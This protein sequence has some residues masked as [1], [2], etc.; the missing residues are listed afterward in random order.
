MLD[1]ESAKSS[2]VKYM[3]IHQKDFRV[4]KAYISMFMQ[5]LD[6]GLWKVCKYSPIPL[7]SL[8]VNINCIVLVNRFQ[9][10]MLNIFRFK[11]VVA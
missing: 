3:L 9:V 4:N 5:G 2:V 7:W 6:L 11:L 10:S 1:G 8:F